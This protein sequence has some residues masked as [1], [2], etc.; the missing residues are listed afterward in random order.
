M[1]YEKGCVTTGVTQPFL[2]LLYNIT[3]FFIDHKINVNAFL[4]TF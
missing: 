1:K 3:F 4:P 2:S